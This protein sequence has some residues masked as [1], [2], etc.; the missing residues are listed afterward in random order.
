MK[1]R[2]LLIVGL[3][4]VMFLGFGCNGEAQKADAKN[5]PAAGPAAAAA[6]I[7]G[8]VTETMDS[9]GYTYVQIDTGSKKVWAAG[10]QTPLKVGDQI[11]IPQGMAMQNFHSKTL[12][13]DFDVIY[14]VSV[15]GG[16]GSHGAAGMMGMTPPGHPTPSMGSTS[17]PGGI[18]A[19]EK[20]EIKAGSIKKADGGST[21]EEVFKNKTTLVDKEVKIRGKVV[22]FSSGI[23]GKN[24]LHLQDGT[25]VEGT[26]DLTVTTGIS[27]NKGDTVL[28]KGKLAVDKDFGYGYKYAVILEDA[29]VKVE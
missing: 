8:T 12:N 26:N 6:Q 20:V 13:R 16:G 2:S 28:V 23:M 27:V 15:I 9:G 4:S 10:P 14:F 3:M 29:D 1:K 17:G 25:G 5:G 19:V 22:K 7:S 24:W 11:S 18:P 21:V